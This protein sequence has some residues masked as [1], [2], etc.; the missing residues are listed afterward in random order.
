LSQTPGTTTPASH[1]PNSAR[2]RRPQ[3]DGTKDS[4]DWPAG[5]RQTDVTQVGIRAKH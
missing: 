2:A 5:D 4:H 1:A 3:R